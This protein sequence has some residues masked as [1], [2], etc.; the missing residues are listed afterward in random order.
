MS[1]SGSHDNSRSRSCSTPST[2]VMRRVPSKNVMG[3]DRDKDEDPADTEVMAGLK[4]C[5]HN[6]AIS[7]SCD[8]IDSPNS[9]ID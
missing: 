6:N 5:L 1:N 4:Y 3:K 2:G 8:V 7:S 9:L